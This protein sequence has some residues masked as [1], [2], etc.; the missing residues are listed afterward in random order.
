[1]LQELLW[2]FIMDN[3]FKNMRANAG[4]IDKLPLF[5]QSRKIEYVT[6]HRVLCSFNLP[7]WR[8]DPWRIISL[9]LR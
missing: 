5:Q 1:M 2:P 4:S 3:K 9:I 6:R 8:S 7:E